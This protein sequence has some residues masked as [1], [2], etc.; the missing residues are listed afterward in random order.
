MD[1]TTQK[2]L[3]TQKIINELLPRETHGFDTANSPKGLINDQRTAS[4]GDAGIR[5]RKQPLGPPK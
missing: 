5:K 2:A 4:M 1:S 3:G